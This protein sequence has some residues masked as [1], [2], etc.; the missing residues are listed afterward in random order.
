MCVCSKVGARKRK[1]RSRHDSNRRNTSHG[2]KWE[3]G[4]L[5]SQI[6]CINETHSKNST[7][8]A[9]KEAIWKMPQKETMF[10]G[11]NKKSARGGFQNVLG[12]DSTTRRAEASRAIFKDRS[13]SVWRCLRVACNPRIGCPPDAAR[14]W[15]KLGSSAL[16]ANRDAE[17]TP[18][19]E[20][21]RIF[22]LS[23]GY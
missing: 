9:Q 14:K 16:Q 19:P 7:G 18:P 2:I 23:G 20:P 22:M 3:R 6:Y 10:Q 11:R 1:V 17:K 13:A 21:S 5:Q 4:F 12:C 15:L 8:W